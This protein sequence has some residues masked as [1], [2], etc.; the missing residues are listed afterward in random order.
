M[1]TGD[2][3]KWVEEWEEDEMQ[4]SKK[5]GN[6]KWKQRMRERRGEKYEEEEKKKYKAE[7]KEKE[8]YKCGYV[9][10]NLCSHQKPF[11][12]TSLVLTLY[13]GRD[14]YYHFKGC[15]K[16]RYH[17]LIHVMLCLD[18]LCFHLTGCGSGGVCVASGEAACSLNSCCTL[19]T[20]VAI[21]HVML[22]CAIL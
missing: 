21:C 2:E 18:G 7:E 6:E 12:I 4:A 11:F 17:V 22:S 20:C 3:D 9:K 15:T 13:A 1:K 5:R 8:E 16:E 14:D 10:L 19:V